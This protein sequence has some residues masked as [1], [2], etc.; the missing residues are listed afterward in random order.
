[1]DWLWSDW[2]WNQDFLTLRGKGNFKYVFTG[3]K[4]PVSG[5]DIDGKN[6]EDCMVMDWKIE[7]SSTTI[8]DRKCTGQ[9]GTYASICEV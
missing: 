7:S 3:T 9:Y 1:M 6:G 4:S 2:T 5:T 8:D